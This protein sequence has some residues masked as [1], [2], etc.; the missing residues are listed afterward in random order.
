[1]DPIREGRLSPARK[2]LGP[3][4]I[5]QT[6][7]VCESIN[8]LANSHLAISRF[9]KNRQH[10]ALIVGYRHAQFPVGATQSVVATS[11]WVKLGLANGNLR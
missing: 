3:I 1:V 6:E 5:T 11:Q 9:F 8:N 4:L 7:F 2:Q 10:Q